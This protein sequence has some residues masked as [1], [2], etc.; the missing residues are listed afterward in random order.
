MN[1]GILKLQYVV[2]RKFCS[3]FIFKKYSWTLTIISSHSMFIKD[4]YLFIY[5]NSSAKFRV[6][7]NAFINCPLPISMSLFI[8]TSQLTYFIKDLLKCPAL[9][10]KFKSPLTGCK[11]NI[12]CLISK[13]TL[14]TFLWLIIWMIMLFYRF[15]SF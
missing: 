12:K 6:P 2:V 15:K 1:P 9:P 13:G 8:Y 10:V 3:S 5:S 14:F 11:H 7:T 4:I